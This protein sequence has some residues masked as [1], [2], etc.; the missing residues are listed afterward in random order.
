[1]HRAR[2]A[3]KIV[4][5]QVEGLIRSRPDKAL[6]DDILLIALERYNDG[7]TT[8][9]EL[10]QSQKAVEA[11]IRQ[12]IRDANVIVGRRKSLSKSRNAAI[13][14]VF[15][16]KPV[17]YLTGQS[18]F[19]AY[20]H[21]FVFWQDHVWVLSAIEPTMATTHLH[22]RIVERS[23]QTYRNFADAQDRLSDL[24]PLLLALGQRRRLRGQRANISYFISP[25]ADGLMFGD[26]AK[27]PSRMGADPETSANPELIE[28]VAAE[29]IAYKHELPDIYAN[30]HFR[31]CVQIRTFVG[32]NEMKPSQREL[33][34]KL[35]RFCAA[36]RRTIDFMKLNA[37]LG[38]GRY[39]GI[40]TGD[41]FGPEMIEILDPPKP[42]AE[43]IESAVAEI[44][45]IS[46]SELW[47]SEV[48]F[49]RR[50]QQ[51]GSVNSEPG[52]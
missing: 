49:S 17:P 18:M 37:R 4:A 7:P 52:V 13:V 35:N 14:L 29:K 40:D 41:R 19:G 26:L 12:K 20:T 24:L 10:V 31:L 39:Q 30:D 36:H 43:D 11:A 2:T 47:L 38:I 42:S 27:L 1:M 34:G 8:N 50:N 22:A 15:H 28:F 3:K 51:G 23:K 32:S 48:E 16:P 46:S 25:W 45:K 6:P 5:A 9:R 21:A 44:D 33:F